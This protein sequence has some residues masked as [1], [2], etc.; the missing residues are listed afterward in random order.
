MNF[1]DMKKGMVSIDGN[2]LADMFKNRA[3]FA[4]F[5]QDSFDTGKIKP[6]IK[7]AKAL[8]ICIQGTK[9]ISISDCQKVVENL[10]GAAS[11][12][13]SVIWGARISTKRKLMVMAGWK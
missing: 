1:F 9:S 6:R 8:V 13:A 3:D 5:I 10:A 11:P 2:D 4:V 7:D 12:K